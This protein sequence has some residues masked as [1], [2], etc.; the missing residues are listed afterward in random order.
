MRGNQ[1]PVPR[2]DEVE[3]LIRQHP[4]LRDWRLERMHRRQI[5]FSEVL[6]YRRD[7]NSELPL[8]LVKHRLG[9]VP[10]ERTRESL[11]R[12]FRGLEALWDRAGSALEGTVPRPVAYLPEALAIVLEKL[13]GKNLETLM[14]RQAN[15]AV[16]VFT[17]GKFRAIAVRFGR[18]VRRFH[19]ATAE[20]PAVH[21]SAAY[22]A[23]VS[24]WLDRCRQTGLDSA[25]ADQ[26]LQSAERAS[27][28]LE[29]E[30]VLKAAFHGD[31]IP[32]N[33]LVDGERVAVVD[34]GGYQPSEPVYDD[35]GFV[36]AYF[37]MMEQSG[38]YSVRLIRGMA[39]GFLEGYG[40]IESTGLLNLYT[41]RGLLDILACQFH[42]GNRVP[43]KRAKLRRFS[44]Y[45]SAES[46]RLLSTPAAH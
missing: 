24:A 19:E 32:I 29:G 4:A 43:E 22:V 15:R 12:E 36:L 2:T 7:S 28:G 26:V 10:A 27:R 6:E 11:A 13:P 20:P 33:I 3:Q 8:L 37:G 23:K 18:W 25:V 14:K 31:L 40:E 17:A 34:F 35:L 38:S 1:K 21:D 41:L 42:W 44:E 9:I 46:D 5:K 16:G 45:L 39:E 30:R